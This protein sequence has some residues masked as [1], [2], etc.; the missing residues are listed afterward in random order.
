LGHK[1][2]FNKV[3]KMK[4]EKLTRFGLS[5]LLLLA[6][7]LGL[8]PGLLAAPPPSFTAVEIT[9]P[10]G[11]MFPYGRDLNE[12]GQVT[13]DYSVVDGFY[14]F[15]WDRV[16]GPQDLGHPAGGMPYSQFINNQGRTA[17]F[18]WYQSEEGVSFRAF[19]WDPK[20]LPMRD[21]G[22]LP[23]YDC[24][25]T[26]NMN[27][28]GQIIGGSY[29][30]DTSAACLWD[31]ARNY[32]PL[33]LQPLNQGGES[34]A[35]S[36]NNGG[37]SRQINF[38]RH[39]TSKPVAIAGFAIN[40][41]N[42]DHAVVWNTQGTVKD[43]GTLGGNNSYAYAVNDQGWV[44]GR[45]DVTPQGQGPTFQVPHNQHAFLWKGKKMLDL[46]VLTGETGTG[47][48]S[49]AVMIN[50]SG[51][52]VG[53]G[54]LGDN[55]Q[56]FAWTAKDG[57]VS[58]SAPGWVGSSRPR[59]NNYG[60]VVGRYDG[61]RLEGGQAGNVFYW[62]QATGPYDLTLLVNWTTAQE[63]VYLTDVQ[64]INDRG[65]VLARGSDNKP[66]LLV[67]QQLQKSRGGV[68]RSGWY[69]RD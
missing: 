51:M 53:E 35:A 62:S 66:Y 15:I 56:A 7:V 28:R 69:V 4:H 47:N 17:G 46:G 36:I 60:Q 9:P 2:S 19:S 25:D 67:P 45:S 55:T 59:V 33:L 68:P 42:Y 58:L 44:V 49:T 23:G 6:A 38:F 48:W 63:G 16:N 30:F 34:W 3:R 1:D 26:H 27:N 50:N 61:L 18:I 11:G 8:A 31:P 22:A 10:A 24:S 37:G 43:L 12:Q 5:G 14:S 21:L 41:E 54:D 39:Q 20:N 65:M 40:A 32:Q 13:G 52:V 64:G 57:M 29:S